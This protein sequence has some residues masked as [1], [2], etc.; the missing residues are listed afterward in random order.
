M[1]RQLK[2]LIKEYKNDIGFA[3]YP[4]GEFIKSL[5]N[6]VEFIPD[7]VGKPGQHH[8]FFEEH[9]KLQDHLKSLNEQKTQQMELDD[10]KQRALDNAKRF[11]VNDSIIIFHGKH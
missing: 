11:A 5:R 9:E 7:D 4:D 2:N 6:R 3:S 10:Y 8:A 1:K